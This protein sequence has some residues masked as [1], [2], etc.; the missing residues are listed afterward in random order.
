VEGRP[1]APRHLFKHKCVKNDGARSF[2]VVAKGKENTLKASEILVPSNGAFST[3]PRRD[4]ESRPG[5]LAL[6]TLPVREPVQY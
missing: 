2:S 4:A 5:M 3:N 1:F 6:A